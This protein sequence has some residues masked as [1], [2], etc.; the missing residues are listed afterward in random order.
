MSDIKEPG[1]DEIKSGDT[2]TPESPILNTGSGSTGSAKVSIE[3][4]APL[5]L[6]VINTEQDV[7]AVGSELSPVLQ[8]MRGDPTAQVN[9]Q[10]FEE[11]PVEVCGQLY[12]TALEIGYTL[13]NKGM[14]MRELPETRVKTQG[15]IIYTIMKKNQI[16]IKHIDLFMLGAGMVGDWK[17]MD[18]Y[19]DE[20]KTEAASTSSDKPDSGATRTGH[21]KD[22]GVKQ[23]GEL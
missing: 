5:S 7:G 19:S 14:P 4:T 15:E 20:Q 10:I 1:S 18:S 21:P 2:P 23:Y 13:K 6:P 17:F 22:S 9:E 11:I 8:E 12:K 16:S 3:E